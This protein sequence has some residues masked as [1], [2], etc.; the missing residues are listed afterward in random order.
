MSRFKRFAHSLVSGYA[1]I[2]VNVLYTLAS[3]PLALH[4]LSKE[5]FGLWAVVSQ[6]CNF[7]ML[8]VDLGMSGAVARILIDHKD[9]STSTKYGEVIQTGLLVLLVQ[10]VILAIAGGLLSYWLPQWMAVEVKYW[11]I[12]RQLVIWQCVLL[13]LSFVLRIFAFIL[14]AHQRYDMC[15]YANLTGFVAGLIGLWIGFAAGWGLYS[16]LLGG[17]AT[18]VLTSAANVWQTWRLRLFPSRDRWGKANTAMFKELFS[19]GSNVF[20]AAIGLQLI[21]AVQAPIITR[22][23]GL[24]AAAVWSIA[25]K[26]FMLSQQ[27]VYRLLDYSTAAIS[28]MIVRGEK[29]RLNARF[30]DLVILSGSIGAAVGISMAVCNRGF[31]NIWTDGRV[32][33]SVENDLLMAISLFIYS[34]I[35]CHLGLAFATKQIRALKYIYLAEGILFVALSMLLAPLIGLSGVIAAGI[36]TNLVFSGIYGVNRTTEFFQLPSIQVAIG[37][38]R[39]PMLVFVV[40]LAIAIGLWFMVGALKTDA[41][42]ELLIFASVMSVASV[43]C[44]WFLGI[45]EKLRKECMER[46]ERFR[47]RLLMRNISGTRNLL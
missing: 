46:L 27:L 20:L 32:E 14:Q 3:V 45:P 18:A 36:F 29:A 11:S 28:E 1:L 16:M 33:W 7:N 25:T 15:N 2:V 30:Q 12:F 43:L 19:F 41:W 6:V 5:E 23:L 24:E 26:L 4:Y 44:L 13:A 31:L 35:R 37:W 8:V 38:M 39:R 9:D 22:T 21:V 40:L 17:A 10:G 34:S 42:L 47:K